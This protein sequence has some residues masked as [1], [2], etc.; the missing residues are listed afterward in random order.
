MPTIRVIHPFYF[1]A[2]KKVPARLFAPG[3]HTLTDDEFKHW[4]IQGCLAD[5]RAEEA[6]DPAVLAAIEAA[7]KAAE[8]E[9]AKVAAIEAAKKA[10]EEEAAKVAAEEAAKK[11]A[12]E[13]A[14]KATEPAAEAVEPTKKKGK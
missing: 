14:A 12:E 10:A 11:A 9:A 8:E 7:K 13:E 6:V 3:V 1:S 4:F 2:D 5:G